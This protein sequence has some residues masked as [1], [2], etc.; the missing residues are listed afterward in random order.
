MAVMHTPVD[1]TVAALRV[2]CECWDGP[3][4]P[5]PTRG[6]WSPVSGGSK[7]WP[8][9]MKEAEEWVSLG[10]Q[11]VGACCGMGPE[12]IKLLKERLPLRVR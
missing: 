9:L 12:H 4:G 10:V 11:V 8:C 5:I 6:R 2:L 3:L 7:G 1:K